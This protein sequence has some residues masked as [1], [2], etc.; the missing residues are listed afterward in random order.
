[1]R[2][3]TMMVLV[4]ATFVGCKK[5]EPSDTAA[6]PAAE[7]KA[8]PAAKPSVDTASGPFA[9]WD[10]P[11]RKAAW[12]GAWAGDAEA[13]GWKAAWQI[14]GDKVTR[15]DSKGEK[16]LELDVVSPCSAKFVEKSASGSSST[17]SVYTLQNGA[18]ITGLGDAGSRKGDQAV[19]CGGG[20]IFTL[21]AKGCTEWEDN[22]G[23][24]ASNPGQ[25]GFR[26]DGDKEVFFYNANGHESVL[27]VDG[28]VIWSEQLKSTHATKHPDL[29]AAKKAQGF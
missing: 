20:K 16:Q 5:K 13:A 19:V 25:C 15:V 2:K 7:D 26:K 1:M 22:F 21:D 14:D 18:L 23:K 9:A 17:T 4:F 3:T 12:Q 10:M 24:L 28:D 6:K 29:A 8:A 11:A 27:G